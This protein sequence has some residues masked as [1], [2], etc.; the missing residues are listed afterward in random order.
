MRGVR[1]VAVGVAVGLLLTPVSV[2]AF[3]GPT[4]G[5]IAFSDSDGIYTID[6]DGTDKTRLTRGN[7]FSAVWAPDGSMIAF[8]R[9]STNLG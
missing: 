7:R 3:P 4:F 5:K 2:H 1:A 9:S 6:A 8:V